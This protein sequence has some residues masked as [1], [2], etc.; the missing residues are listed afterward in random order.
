MRLVSLLRL[1]SPIFPASFSTS[2]APLL[3]F[4]APSAPPYTFA[5]IFLG[6]FA[7]FFLFSLHTDTHTTHMH[8]LLI[9]S[10]PSLRI[11]KRRVTD[12]AEPNRNE[13]DASS[14]P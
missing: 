10:F 6:H 3:L 12:R 8:N 14:R 7:I 11:V 5:C 13:A 2:A 4:M 9:N 1:I